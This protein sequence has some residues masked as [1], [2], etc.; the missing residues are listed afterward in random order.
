MS[1]MSGV[2]QSKIYEPLLG[3]KG[4]RVSF[5]DQLQCTLFTRILALDTRVVRVPFHLTPVQCLL[6]VG[7]KLHVSRISFIHKEKIIKCIQCS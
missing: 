3:R 1:K 5:S 2:R 6:Y 7:C 4:L